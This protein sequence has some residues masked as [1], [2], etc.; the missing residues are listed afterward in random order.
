[1]NRYCRTVYLCMLVVLKKKQCMNWLYL[2]RKLE[3]PEM[4]AAL[5]RKTEK[6][7]QCW[8]RYVLMPLKFG[9][10]T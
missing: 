7:R 10:I 5:R 8:E 3:E 6:L 1:M 2:Q 9:P 4:L